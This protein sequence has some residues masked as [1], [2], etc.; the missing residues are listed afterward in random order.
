MKRPGATGKGPAGK[1]AR[2]APGAETLA[3]AARAVREVRHEGRSADAALEACADRADRAA[4][5]AI[6]LGTLRW[7]LR[8]E[9]ALVPLLSRP[10]D[11]LSPQLAALLV[12][13]AHQVEYSRGA[14]EAQV[15]L[16]VDA[17]RIAGEP[18]SS[19]MVNAVLRRFVAERARLLGEV[20]MDPAR[21]HAHPPWLV[22]ALQLAWSERADSILA[23]GNQHP[24][25]VLRLD[26]SQMQTVDF[27]RAWRAA[28]REA[29]AVEWNPDAVVLEHP[30]AV[31]LLPGFDTAAVSVQDAGAQLAAPLLQARAGMR[32]LDACAAPGGKTL[33]IAQRNPDLAELVAADDDARRLERVSENLDR[34]GRAATLLC[35]DLTSA[36]PALA[37]SSFDRV[38]VDAPCSSTG[39]IRRH[40]DIKLLRRSTDIEAF[41]RNQRRILETSFELLKPG[42]RLVYVTCS[43]LPAENDGVVGAF[44]AGQPSAR[45][46][47][48]PEDA[49]RPPDLLE[50]PVG[51]QLLP[52][53][54][55][56]TDGFYYACLTKNADPARP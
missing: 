34:G 4:V 15:H 51:W 17:S 48:W 54:S 16:A 44:L 47:D 7:Y 2:H 40:P 13:A 49:P 18:R 11:E 35:A 23:A 8:L 46:A 1:K 27:L 29:R 21:R 53:G 25:M 33:H 5:R 31:H 41:T 6:T 28:G 38:L 43:V 22:A 19:G 10:I 32:V 9:P 26:P 14:P 52:G 50:R 55:A 3:F 30:V 39:V 24:P 42:G 36:V 56:G 45:A 37:P 20:D 12:T